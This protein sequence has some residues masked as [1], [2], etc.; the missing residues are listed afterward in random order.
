M[1]HIS[2]SRIK[3]NIQIANESNW[4]RIYNILIMYMDLMMDP[5]H[6]SL[7]NYK[8]I[9]YIICESYIWILWILYTD[10]KLIIY[11]AYVSHVNYIYGYYGSYTEIT[12][13]LYID[14]ICMWILYMELMDPVHYS[15]MNQI[16]MWT[17]NR[18]LT[19]ESYLEIAKDGSNI[20]IAYII[21]E[22]YTWILCMD[23][24]WIVHE[25]YTCS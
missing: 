18:N 21:C 4:H 1:N 3:I 14:R 17:V 15:R 24:I 16:K 23:Q 9:V 5:I 19:H 7:M 10:P 6:K 11:G 12:N 20:W 13:E 8:W 22:S 25:S 2:T